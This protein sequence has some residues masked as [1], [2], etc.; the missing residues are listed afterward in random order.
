MRVRGRTIVLTFVVIQLC[1]E[2]SVL[3]ESVKSL[4]SPIQLT[5]FDTGY[6][7][8]FDVL[9]TIIL[10]TAMLLNLQL[11]LYGLKGVGFNY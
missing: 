11:F 3:Y 1:L 8:L 4:N 7:H 6:P 10:I 2:Y 5:V 9:L